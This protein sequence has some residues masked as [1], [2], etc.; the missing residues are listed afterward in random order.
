M[1]LEQGMTVEQCLIKLGVSREGVLAVQQGGRVLE[2]NAP[3]TQPGLLH[4]LTMH[5]EEGRRIYERSVRFLL[6]AATN[7]IL[8]GQRVRI[9]YSVSG[10]VLL[11]MPGH[12]I[13]EEETRAIARQMHA[14]AAQNLPFEKKEWT[15]DDAIAYFDAQGQ[16]DKVALLS[17]RTTPFFHMYG[18]DGMWEYFYG[19]MATRT[20][21]R[22]GDDG[23]T[24]LPPLHPP[25]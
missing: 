6:L 2:M 12:A 9:E 20:G 24:P 1:E 16:A 14:L 19:A 15:L 8:P 10:G 18:L 4:L 11:R 25:E 5:T 13:T 7:R 17:R 21:R 22:R 3:V 23:G